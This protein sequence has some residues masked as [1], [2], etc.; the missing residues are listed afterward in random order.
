MIVNRVKERQS[1]HPLIISDLFYDFVF[2]APAHAIY[3]YK[4]GTLVDK[5]NMLPT[6]GILALSIELSPLILNLST[7][8]IEQSTLNFHR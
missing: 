4:Y 2:F 7:F 8:I 3:Y 5:G 6:F 1:S